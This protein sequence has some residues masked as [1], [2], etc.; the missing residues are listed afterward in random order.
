MAIFKV[1]ITIFF[2]LL[3]GEKSLGVLNKGINKNINNDENNNNIIE[4]RITHEYGLPPKPHFDG[5]APIYGPPELTGNHGQQQVFPP[6]PPDVPPPL[7]IG[8]GSGIKQ[9]SFY[10]PPRNN[11]QFGPRPPLKLS[12]WK[13]PQS[14]TRFVTKPAG[15][16]PPI[17]I[18]VESYGPPN[19]QQPPNFS[20]SQNQYGPPPPPQSYPAFSQGPQV[21]PPGVPAPP[22]PPDIK[23]DGWQP[24]AGHVETPSTYQQPEAQNNNINIQTNSYNE[25]I[26]S[27]ESYNNLNNNINNNVINNNNNNNNVNVPS[28]SYGEP[29]HSQEDHNLRQAVVPNGSDS[30]LPPPQLPEHEPLHNIQE[31]AKDINIL[32]TTSK[33][34]TF[35]T[36]VENEISN[37][38]SNQDDLSFKQPESLSQSAG[39]TDSYGAPL[40]PSSFSANGPYQQQSQ[41]FSS[42]GGSSFNQQ[43]FKQQ[44]RQQHSFNNF[45]PQ[46]NQPSFRPYPP[47]VAFIPPRN[48]AP[49]KFRESIPS[50]VLNSVHRYRQFNS[51]P[52]PPSNFGFQ[53][54]PPTTKNA[55]TFHAA[56]PSSFENN[57]PS[58]AAPNFNYGT[59]LTF[60]NFNTP[61]PVL[62]YGAPNF[63][64]TGSFISQSFGGS[65]G[66]LYQQNM[67]GDLPATYGSPSPL[68]IA[69]FQFARQNDCSQKNSA[70]NTLNFENS[71]F[72]Q[73]NSGI[74]PTIDNELQLPLINQLELEPHNNIPQTDIKDS[75]GNPAGITTDLRSASSSQ[76]GVSHTAESLTAA[77][78]AQGYTQQSSDQL[79]STNELNIDQLA[80]I[81]DEPALA[82]AQTLAA[83]G[84][85]P[86][87]FQI[88]GSKGTYTLQVQPAEPHSN[89]NSDGTIRHDRLLSNGLLQDILAAIEQPNH[90]GTPQLIS[91]QG[92]PQSQSLQQV[93]DQKNYESHQDLTQSASSSAVTSDSQINSHND[94]P[95]I[96]DDNIQ[97]FFN[98]SNN[99]D[100]LNDNNNH[101]NFE[102]SNKEIRSTS[103]S[104]GVVGEAT[105]TTTT[106]KPSESEKPS[107]K[108]S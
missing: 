71:Q 92:S 34:P 79:A 85:S 99:N 60:K 82:L 15:H 81:H 64:P 105:T 37:H 46:R 13:L 103:K 54:Q 86:D 48:R 22:T 43:S 61:A 53:Q 25:Q 3:I 39:L 16:G 26:R 83:E 27:Q 42:F 107:Q 93:N 4:D 30:G 88:Q 67:V 29:I 51:A 17:P 84:A 74:V 31:P 55:V 1:A 45:P 87:G 101:Q 72:R 75:Y 57:L 41:G 77:L 20:R 40:P 65:N 62:T 36:S 66:N 70:Y 89:E 94:L 68:P 76:V 78:T 106:Q 59:P 11:Q 52:P 2:V 100:I 5:P 32:P 18:S 50:S 80:Q 104:E 58:F 90:Q 95:T 102:V 69:Q 97:L 10:S 14:Q 44:H 28:N 19:N 73:V 56:A 38:I 35:F 23:F 49:H 7:P 9:Q 21:P 6:P 47:P 24:I 8:H 91:I 96:H 33:T 63:G 98:N 12:P 108:A